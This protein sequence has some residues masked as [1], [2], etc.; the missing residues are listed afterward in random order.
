MQAYQKVGAY[1]AVEN[2][3][4]HR[5]IE[6]LFDGALARVAKAKA[7]IAN[8]DVSRKG[9]TI[10]QAINIVAGLRG[11]LNLEDGGDIAANLDDLYD[12]MQ[13]KLA[14]ANAR[15]SVEHLDEIA[16]LLTE[17]QSAWRQIPQSARRGGG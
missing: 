7:H 1:G 12:Y 5:L 11:S 13:R 2:N 10:G 4:P 14:L 6:L 17:L 3:D 15:S 9:E 8:G 16:S